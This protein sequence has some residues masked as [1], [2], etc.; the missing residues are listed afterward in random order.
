[1]NKRLIIITAGAGLLSFG[2]A[3]VLAWLTAPGPSGQSEQPEGVTESIGAGS[4]LLMTGSEMAG[5]PGPVDEKL[6]KAM[7]EKQLKGLVYEIRETIDEYNKKLQV[8][9]VREQRLETAHASLKQDIEKLNNLRVELA[10]MVGHLK[11]EQDKLDKQ[12]IEVAQTERANLLSIAA[13]YDRMDATSASK[14]LV[15]MCISK[16]EQGSRAHVG[17]PGSNM[18]DAVK[19]LHY[20]AERTKAKLLAELVNFEPALAAVLCQRLKRIVEQE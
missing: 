12:R 19:I 11:S 18:D 8:L 20:M 16:G 10:S 5:A 3:F 1:V 7:T 13:A 17:G 15:N 6:K 2:G 14:I 4:G 9:E